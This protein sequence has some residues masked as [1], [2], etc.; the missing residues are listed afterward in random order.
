MEI[1]SDPVDTKME[2]DTKEEPKKLG[3]KVIRLAD[4]FDRHELIVYSNIRELTVRNLDPQDAVDVLQYVIS[5][6]SAQIEK[7]DLGRDG[8]CNLSRLV[9]MPKFQGQFKRLQ[10]LDLSGVV[11][12]S[13]HGLLELVDTIWNFSNLTLILM[14]T[15][16]TR[17][18]AL[19]QTSTEVL[20]ISYNYLDSRD[21]GDVIRFLENSPISTTK[22]SEK[23]LLL[24][25]NARVRC[26][27]E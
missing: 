18:K 20:N 5:T 23:S 25:L 15:H 4:G 3:A 7:L 11:D 10:Y 13:G 19:R 24:L 21:V 9:P 12:L 6:R 16:I 26:L 8:L 27:C 17:F 14:C 22:T 2:I 1:D